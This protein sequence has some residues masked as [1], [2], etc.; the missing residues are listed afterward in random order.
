MVY[1]LHELCCKVLEIMLLYIPVSLTRAQRGLQY[2]VD[3]SVCL[4]VP[5][6]L[7]PCTIRQPKSDT[8]GFS[9][10]QARLKNGDFRKS[11]A[12]KVMV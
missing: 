6:F 3:V 4:S 2:L 12:F 1:I 8:N 5:R 10:T 11:T 7:P 9:A